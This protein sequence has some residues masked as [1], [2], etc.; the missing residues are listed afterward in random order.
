MY[1]RQFFLARM[2]TCVGKGR[3]GECGQ[4]KTT[5]RRELA[6]LFQD[7]GHDRLQYRQ[8]WAGSVLQK[9]DLV[10]QEYHMSAENVI[11]P[12]TCSWLRLEPMSKHNSWNKLYTR[13]LPITKSIRYELEPR[14]S[15]QINLSGPVFCFSDEILHR[16]FDPPSHEIVHRACSFAGFESRKFAH[17][18]IF[19]LAFIFFFWLLLL[20]RTRGKE[21][22]SK[23]FDHLVA[24]FEYLTLQ[25]GGGKTSCTPSLENAVDEPKSNVF[26]FRQFAAKTEIP[27]PRSQRA[28]GYAL[29]SPIVWD[30][31][32]SGWVAK[33]LNM[34]LEEEKYSN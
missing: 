4:S 6:Y 3:G 19:D 21:Q 11:R 13:L 9:C 10:K 30:L 1:V 25:P 18:Y 17:I 27:A 29:C 12:P 28:W 2:C 34:L 20:L 33:T 31:V 26:H 7:T 15:L 24:W 32:I 8:K 5:G 14:S 16:A 23:G 22:K